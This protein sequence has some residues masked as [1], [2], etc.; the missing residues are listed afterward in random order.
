MLCQLYFMSYI[1]PGV[2]D[3]AEGGVREHRQ[4]VCVSDFSKP[5]DGHSR[6]IP[7]YTL[8]AP[9]EAKPIL[10]NRA[11]RTIDLSS[12]R[13]SV[14]LAGEYEAALRLFHRA[15]GSVAEEQISGAILEAIW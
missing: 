10:G 9:S 4:P 8:A 7:C 3:A 1:V 14:S 6:H 15:L 12:F 2:C 11:T 5:D 13:L